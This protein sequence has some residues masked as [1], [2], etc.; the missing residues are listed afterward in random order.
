MSFSTIFE[1]YSISNVK[2]RVGEEEIRQRGTSV[3][4]L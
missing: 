3:N 1:F 4:H 2:D